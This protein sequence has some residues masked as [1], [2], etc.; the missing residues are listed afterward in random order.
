LGAVDLHKDKDDAKTVGDVIAR[1][2]AAVGVGVVARINDRGDGIEIVDTAG[3]EGKITVTE[4]GNGT[5]AKDLHLLGTSVGADVDGELKQVIDGTA[6][7]TV[8]IDDDDKLSDVV[9]KINAL[10]RGVTASVLNDG[11]R[12]RLSISV[13]KSGAANELLIDTTNTRLSLQEV[14]SGRDALILYGTRGS[15]GILISSSSSTFSNIIDGLDLTVKEGSQKPVTV[16]VSAS[17]TSLVSTA[18]DF[19]SAFNSL[20]DT[21]DKMTAYD[22]DTS[23]AGILFGSS[24]ALQVESNVLILITQQFFGV[25]QFQSMAEVGIT[26]NDKG[27][28][29]LDESKLNAAYNKDPDAV[30]KLFSDSKRGMAT[31]LDAAI[32]RLA[33]SH[34]SVLSSRTDTLTHT[35][36]SNTERIDQMTERL[37]RQREVLLNQFAALE[38]TIARMKD[39]LSALSSLQIIPPLTSSK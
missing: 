27:K 34:D 17:T 35:I 22:A 4:V 14:S 15:G 36:E 26:V 12:Q 21:L 33:A 20:R 39:N 3:G 23:T 5:A 19:V 29:S 10:G 37:D 1:I 38:S 11:T 31:K 7:A 24:E 8:T 32:E 13:D 2:N 16:N 18:K 6:T 30:K 9:S 25:G 28:I